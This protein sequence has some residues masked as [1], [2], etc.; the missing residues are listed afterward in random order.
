MLLYVVGACYIYFRSYGRW[1]AALKA[2]EINVFFKVSWVCRTHLLWPLYPT[3]Y[4][5]SQAC[6]DTSMYVTMQ[7]DQNKFVSRRLKTWRDRVVTFA[8]KKKKNGGEND[9]VQWYGTELVY[10]ICARVGNLL[11]RTVARH[12]PELCVVF[13]KCMA[14]ASVICEKKR[15]NACILICEPRVLMTGQH[16]GQNYCFQASPF[17]S[18]MLREKKMKCHGNI[19]KVN[20]LLSIASPTAIRHGNWFCLSQ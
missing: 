3:A 7:I 8:N 19:C 5:A 4:I 11:R 13:L 17:Q 14:P 6:S 1:C 12:T 18:T 10:Y 20:C 2:T 9:K 15:G 16:R